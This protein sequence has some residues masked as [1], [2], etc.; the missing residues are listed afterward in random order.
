MEQACPARRRPVSCG[1]VASWW[2]R[3]P[4]AAVGLAP[5]VR[6]RAYDRANAGERQPRPRRRPR[7]R[8]TRPRRPVSAQGAERLLALQ[9]DAGN[10]AVGRYIAAPP[11]APADRSLRADRPHRPARPVHAQAAQGDQAALA[12]LLGGGAVLV[13]RRDRRPG[14]LFQDI[15]SRYIATA[16]IDDR[17]SLDQTHAGD[18]FAEWGLAFEF[19]QPPHPQLTGAQWRDKL[20]AHGH[21]LWPRGSRWATRGRLRQ[22][23]RRQGHAEPGL[24]QRDGPDRRGAS[25]LP[26][27]SVPTTISVGWLTTSA[28]GPAACLSQAPPDPPPGG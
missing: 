4:G 27:S 22:R 14:H 3:A 6:G 24:D 8:G 10:A 21:L 7:P 9:R 16:C 1:A 19:F 2:A 26:V 17:N 18:V 25:Q 15:I 5:R 23:L 13:P 28:P 11:A 12:H 20:R